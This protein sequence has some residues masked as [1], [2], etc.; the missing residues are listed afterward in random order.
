VIIRNVD[1]YT[2]TT[3]A[4]K[5]ELALQTL[6]SGY[7]SGPSPDEWLDLGYTYDY[8]GVELPGG[9]YLLTL[10]QTS[11]SADTDIALPEGGI[12]QLALVQATR[13]TVG[14]GKN[15]AINIMGVREP[16]WVL[17]LSLSTAPEGPST[18]VAGMNAPKTASPTP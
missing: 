18:P 15:G 1:G 3:G 16:T 5:V 10:R 4:A 9:P 14:G 2:W 11:V 6:V 12:R 17:V 7:P 13:A 8:R